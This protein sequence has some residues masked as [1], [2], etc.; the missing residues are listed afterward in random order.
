MCVVH[1]CMKDVCLSEWYSGM[2][3][4]CVCMHMHMPVFSPST[5]MPMEARGQYCMSFLIALHLLAQVKFSSEPGAPWFS[6]VG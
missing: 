1:M 4:Y 3:V 2:C 5:G 6:Q